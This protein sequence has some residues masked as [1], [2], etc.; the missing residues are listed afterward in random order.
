[1]SY[2]RL[3]IASE[4]KSHQVADVYFS[5]LSGLH[6]PWTLPVGGVWRRGT[7][8]CALPLLF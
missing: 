1:M 8:L 6:S 7:S 2:L 5:Q 4:N 3:S